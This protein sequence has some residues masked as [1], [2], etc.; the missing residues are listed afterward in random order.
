MRKKEILEWGSDKNLL[1]P[2][3]APQQFMKLSEEVGE[4]ANAIL[5]RNKIEQIDALGDIKVVITILAEQL[6]FDID[7]CEEIAYQEIKNRTGKTLNGTFLK[8]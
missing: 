7:E 1:N 3:F 4:L 5:K 8:D 2:E 6:G